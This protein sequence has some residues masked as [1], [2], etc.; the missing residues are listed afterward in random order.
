MC[1]YNELAKKNKK[2]SCVLQGWTNSL[3][4]T[5]AVQE[6]QSLGQS[7]HSRVLIDE[8]WLC[9]GSAHLRTALHHAAKLV[10]CRLRRLPSH[11]VLS[12]ESVLTI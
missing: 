2:N 7:A 1:T 5:V 8:S 12:P 10:V 3:R 11:S 4:A 6:A 9:T